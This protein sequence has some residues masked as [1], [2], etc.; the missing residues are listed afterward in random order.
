MSNHRDRIMR[1]F[2]TLK[3]MFD[4]R[5][6]PHIVELLET[7]GPQL[8]EC[9]RAK[10]LFSLDFGDKLRV[11]Y[12]MEPKLKV[13]DVKKLIEDAEFESIIIII[14]DKTTASNTKSLLVAGKN[15][16]VFELAEL[17]VNITKLTSLVPHH[18][19]IDN[20]EEIKAITEKL[21][22]EKPALFPF[23]LKT[24]P[25]AKFLNAKPGDLLE[26]TR[27]SPTCAETVFYRICV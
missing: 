12:C 9:I 2:Q 18:R 7:V 8:E 22:I 26:I 17:Q 3:E 5:N 20:S 11:V 25:M 16:Q 15:I 10:H 23:I 27:N 14:R 6:K 1:S 21:K 4:A 24:D 19:L 13:Q